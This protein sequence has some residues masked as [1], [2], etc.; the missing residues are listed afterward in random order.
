MEPDRSSPLSRYTR[1]ARFAPLGDAGQAAVERARV[2]IVG[3]GAL[4]SVA[5]DMLVRAGV[6]RVDLI[7]RDIADL[8]NL[9]RM[10]LLDESDVSEGLPK[11]V[12]VARHL[13]RIRSDVVAEPFVTDLDGANA[14][15]LL[16]GC[17]LVLDGTDNFE[18]R[19]VLNEACLDLGTPWIHAAV[20]GSQAIA[21]PILPGGACYACLVP[22]APAPGEAATCESAG[23]IGAAVHLAAAL[24]ACEALKILSGRGETLPGPWSVD[25]WNRAVARVRAERSASCATC[26]GGERRF[27]G[28]PRAGDAIACGRSAVQVL[29]GESPPAN[30]ERLRDRLDGVVDVRLNAFT[31]RF[32]VGENDMT[33]FRDGRVLVAGTRDVGRARTLVAQYLG[34]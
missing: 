34:R 25:P 32:R 21:W 29:P 30:L 16:R 8:S 13:G 20:L 10:A 15:A 23:I 1:Q 14:L 18:A 9:H 7:D 2:A 4:G 3:C 17:D 33:V 31:L 11:A 22:D 27:L 6:A 26:V 19:L 5:A 24:Q 12:A 28:R